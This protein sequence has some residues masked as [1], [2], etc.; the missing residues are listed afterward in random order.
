[1]TDRM[2]PGVGV[3]RGGGWTAP[4]KA[5]DPEEEGPLWEHLV[6]RDVSAED[7]RRFEGSVAEIFSAFGM[8]RPCSMGPRGTKAM[9][10][11]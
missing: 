7:W 1:M 10:S 3:A 4:L 11:S 2:D 8:D 6:P 5:G 9:P